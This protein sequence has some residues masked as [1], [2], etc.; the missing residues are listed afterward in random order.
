MRLVP[1]A[2]VAT[3]G[4]LITP[5]L[6]RGQ[7]RASTKVNV[8]RE[9]FRVIRQALR[10]AVTHGTG[11]AAAL[12]TIA[13]SGKTGTAQVFAHP[14]G[15]DADDLPKEER[16]HA[17]FA[18]YAPQENPTIAFAVVVEHGGHGGTSAA[19]IAR[20]VLKLFFAEKIRQDQ[21][22][23]ARGS[24]GVDAPTRPTG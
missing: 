23:Q 18:G 15:I 3:K 20:R 1:M 7:A 16:D 9:T 10:D 11:R 13:V 4:Q 6:T 21:E 24:G 8:S 22:Q 14:A 19:P 5:H 17:W 12:P 2:V